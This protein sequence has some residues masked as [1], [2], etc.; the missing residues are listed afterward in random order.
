M[1][2]HI[3]VA[4]PAVASRASDRASTPST[5]ASA[6]TCLLACVAPFELT[7]PLVRLP[8][9]SVSNLEVLVAVSFACW[10]ASLAWSRQR[11]VWRTSLSAPWVA[12]IAVMALAAAAA[13]S[14][15]ANALHMTGRV[16]AAL[17][18]YLLA[19]NGITS[20]AR[21][22]RVIVAA[23]AMGVVVAALAILESLQVSAV[24]NG[25]KAFRPSISVVGAQL[26]AG[27]PL[28]YPTIASMVLE[29]AFA[30]GIG[31]L[32]E[33]IDRRNRAASLAIVVALL[34]IAEGVILTFTRA[35]LLSMAVI[36]SL[37]S[38]WRV[39]RLGID[40]AVRAIGVVA[41]LVGVLFAVSR[42]AQS[43]WLR[44]TS[45]GQENWYRSAIVPPDEILFGADETREIP[46]R[47]TNTGRVTWDSTD[48][49]PFY[50]SYHWLEAASDR[51][52]AF[53]GTR[54]AF[55]TPVSPGD[56]TTVRTIVRAPRHPGGYRIGWDI[57]Q[58]GR[59]WFSTE[60]GATLTMSRATVAG[61]AGGRRPT[62]TAL[63]LPTER[64]GRGLLWSSA[65]RLVLA[66][67]LLGVGPDNFRLLY[68]P[69]A[70]LR[71][72]DRR[73]HSNNMYLEMLVGAGLLGAIAFG[74]LVWRIARLVAAG[75]RIATIDDRMTAS[76]G[77]AAAVGAIGL[78]GLLDSFLS[79]TPTYVLIAL[80]LALAHASAQRATAG[81]HADRV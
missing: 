1:L 63:P 68:G 26:R 34:A 40:S 21:L 49:P 66:H 25:L 45:E 29:V 2:S 24:L 31:L 57:V 80:T 71:N 51:V 19:V 47:V 7:R 72:A 65:A 43:V 58:E 10:L 59:L 64:P 60:P 32:V 67:P 75:V 12:V 48:T 46:I 11:P 81:A 44:L 8:S 55:P 56:T 74:W 77:V 30:L 36:L 70:G 78:H 5:V 3:A 23:V 73:T 53:E 50:L 17:A 69:Y 22:S 79:F 37:V 14:A 9:Q 33:N 76:I 41:V 61:S 15:H 54:T 52:V 6:A 18:I 28:Q 13:P 35:G 20:A 16:A 38:V 42:P 4:T 62:T 39:R 27:G